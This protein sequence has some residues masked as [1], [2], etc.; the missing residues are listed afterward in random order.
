MFAFLLSTTFSANWLST[1]GNKIVDG[2]GSQVKLQGLNWFGFE[3]SVGCFH[4]LWAANL[5]DMVSEVA[6]RGFNVFR[7]PVSADLLHT[8]LDKKPEVPSSMNPQVNPDLDGLT[9]R[10]IFDLF[11]V[12][13]KKEGLKVFI[14][15]HGIA[16]DSYTDALWGTPEYLYKAVEFFADAYKD[17]DT[18][19]GIDIKN[20]PHGECGS[21]S[22]ATWDS[23][24][25]DNNWH[26]VSLTAANRIL[27]KN[28]NLLILVEGIACYKGPRGQDNGWWGGVLSF[29]K[30]LPLDLGKYQNKLVYSPHEYG[31]SVFDQSW[32]QGDFTYD[33]L[34][35]DHWKDSWM[36]IHEDGIAPLLIG[37]WG[38]HIQGTNTKWMQFMVQLIQKN[39]LGHTFWCLNPNSGDT[40]GLINGDWLT[41]DEEKYDLIKPAVSGKLFK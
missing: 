20:E 14:D 9:N 6:K 26:Y 31:P 24:T 2:S 36:F 21:S 34:Y 7:V 37:E 3:T 27:A 11:L 17:D 22:G 1:S 29:V 10:E 39:S 32:F 4:G 28:P 12:D 18:V 16:P 38:G 40:G 35:N 23:S 41:W 25:T 30:D 8:W 15:V 5:H 33:S 13:C 19:I